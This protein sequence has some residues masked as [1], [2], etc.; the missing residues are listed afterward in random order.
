M[1]NDGTV[2][3]VVDPYAKAL[4]VN[5]MRGMVVDL[6][7]TDPEGWENDTKPV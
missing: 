6:D 7:A 5:G 2:N 1:T 4:G 3:E